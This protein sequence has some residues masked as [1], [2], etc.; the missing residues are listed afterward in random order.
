MDKTYVTFL[1]DRSGSMMSCKEATIEGF[2]GYLATLKGDNPAGIEFTFIQFSSISTDKI[3]VGEDVEGVKPL[4]GQTYE[5]EGG[6]PLIDAAYKTI[7]A[8]EVAIA[9]RTDTPKV[10]ICIQTDGHEN[11]STEYNMTQLNA[12]IKEQVALG[13]QFNFMG[14]DIDAYDQARQMGVPTAGTISYNK[15]KSGPAFAAAGRSTRSYA[16]GQTMDTGFTEAEKLDAGD[17]PENRPQQP[18]PA[19]TTPTPQPNTAKAQPIVDD[20]TL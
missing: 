2:N 14:A 13:W 16:T 18:Q 17:L 20:I 11:A 6:T 10:V 9:K 5:P 19:P 3:C 15:M 4:S 12:L 7:K 8:V 1:L